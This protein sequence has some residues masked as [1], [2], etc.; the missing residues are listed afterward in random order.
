MDR[1]NGAVVPLL[2]SSRASLATS[3][4]SP[5]SSPHHVHAHAPSLHSISSIRTAHFQKHNNSDYHANGTDQERD[6]ISDSN[7]PLG[8]SREVSPSKTPR[9]FRDSRLSWAST[10]SGMIGFDEK[11][12]LEAERRWAEIEELDEGEEAEA[13]AAAAAAKASSDDSFEN[14]GMPNESL[15]QHP[16]EAASTMTPSRSSTSLKSILK[17]ST[18]SAEST[19]AAGG[20]PEGSTPDGP[21]QANVQTPAA[22][23]ARTVTFSPSTLPPAPSPPITNVTPEHPRSLAEQL[24]L[25]QQEAARQAVSP[26]RHT[27]VVDESLLSS[28]ES[29]EVEEALL[30]KTSLSTTSNTPSP[31][32]STD[33]LRLQGSASKRGA[34]FITAMQAFIPSPDSSF[35]Q[36]RHDTNYP[37]TGEP[38]PPSLSTLGPTKT[39]NASQDTSNLLDM[40]APSHINDM[41][42]ADD[43]SRFRH[44]FIAP[45]PFLLRQSV[46][47]EESSTVDVSS[48]S[49]ASRG[50]TSNTA[51]GHPQRIASIPSSPTDFHP[52]PSASPNNPVSPAT[53]IITPQ[54]Q[55][56]HSWSA[57]GRKQTS[58]PDRSVRRTEPDQS[59]LGTSNNVDEIDQSQR[60]DTREEQSVFLTPLG[61]KTSDEPHSGQSDLSYLAAVKR[62]G[63]SDTNVSQ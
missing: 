21:S 11:D 2:H 56:S 22:Q 46:I 35:A 47:L 61:D 33:S 58:P 53:P 7:S 62:E 48:A 50:S 49:T 15:R 5:S 6:S 63:G 55:S 51:G 30:S 57:T 9:S 20:M 52:H 3:F 4:A 10:A 28:D 34:G 45:R 40:S 32:D 23:T 16:V 31:D 8:T 12:R 18:A 43:R 26:P 54:R 13:A 38:A 60:G 19:A 25:Q 27:Y 24:Y 59:L 1:A 41:T 17:K 37:K 29:R 36:T 39:V 44:S 42:L 14:Y